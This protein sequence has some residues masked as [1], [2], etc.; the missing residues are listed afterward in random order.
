V[1]AFQ[2]TSDDVIDHPIN[3][4]TLKA[5]VDKLQIIENHYHLKIVFTSDWGRQRTRGVRFQDK[6]RT[7]TLQ[8]M[9]NENKMFVNVST[10][11]GRI[12]YYLDQIQH[13]LN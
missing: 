9:I 4:K 10:V 7:Y 5:F 11:I 6:N 8:E 12:P 3:V 13:N 1:Y 2:S